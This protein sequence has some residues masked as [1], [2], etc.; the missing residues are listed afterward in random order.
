VSQGIGTFAKH[1]ITSEAGHLSAPGAIEA[2]YDRVNGLAADR[3]LSCTAAVLGDALID[4]PP[5]SQVH[6]QVVRTGVDV[7][8]FQIDPVVRLHY[9]EVTPPELA[10]PSGDLA[11]LLDALEAEWQLTGLEA[12]LQVVRALQPALEAGA[13]K[14]TVVVHDMLADRGLARLPRSRLRVAIDVG[15]TTIAGHLA[16]LS[17]GSVLASNVMN[18]QIRSARTGE[19]GVHAMMHPEVLAMTWAVRAALAK[20]VAGLADQADAVA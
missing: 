16:D 9:V 7:R 2:E 10:S 5:E 4:V 18:P 1:G 11:R 6:R 15:S 8:D 14:V 12:D 17:D 3:R 20:L 19:L 13:Y